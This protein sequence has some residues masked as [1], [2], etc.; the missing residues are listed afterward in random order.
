MKM[1]KK[2]G[3][4]YYGESRIT[5]TYDF[6]LSS[7]REYCKLNQDTHSFDVYIHTWNP[8]LENARAISP[9]ARFRIAGSSS[10]STDYLKD[11]YGPVI[12]C[13]MDTQK[14]FIPNEWLHPITVQRTAQSVSLTK[15]LS[16][17]YSIV[18]VCSLVKN[19]E[20]YESFILVRMD[21]VLDFWD[22]PSLSSL[23]QKT[24][25]I[26][27]DWIN[28]FERNILVLYQNLLKFLKETPMTDQWISAESLRYSILHHSQISIKGLWPACSLIRWDDSPSASIN[29]VI[30][31]VSDS[32]LTREYNVMHR[33]LPAGNLICRFQPKKTTEY[34]QWIGISPQISN[35]F[36]VSFR[37]RFIKSYP[38]FIAR[39]KFHHPD[40]I[41]ANWLT[42]EARMTGDWQ[43]I[44]SCPMSSANNP[45]LFLI[46]DDILN[47]EEIIVEFTDVT[48]KDSQ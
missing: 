23:P 12:A 15:A 20:E 37:A 22:F 47:E 30:R 33:Q 34:Y 16:Q 2:V 27:Q 44:T 1:T 29:P 18:Q 5:D 36:T 8:D 21:S 42:E 39:W 14:Q 28:I 6:A 9:S 31:G 40:V 7:I 35:R 4:L 25:W 43:T 17:I 24:V 26:V 13:V 48:V 45:F 10:I 19:P 3:I 32:Y 11:K 46:I 41:L 38:G